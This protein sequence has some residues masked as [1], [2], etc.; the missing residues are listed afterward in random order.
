MSYMNGMWR[1]RPAGL[2]FGLD[3][4]GDRITSPTGL[5]ST[6]TGGASIPAGTGYLSL[7]GTGQWLTT[8]DAAELDVG[9][10][11]SVA[12][13]VRPSSPGTAANRV[14]IARYNAA[15]NK[16]S[17]LVSFRYADSPQRLFA[18]VGTGAA[19]P[20]VYA[21]NLTLPTSGWHHIVMT[22]D[23]SAGAGLRAKMYYDGAALA[24]S[25]LLGDASTSPLVT[26]IGVRVGN[27]ND[28]TAATAWKGDIAEVRQYNRTLTAPEI[29]QLYHAG[30]ARIAQGG[31]P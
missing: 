4:S 24:V 27:D 14:P 1:R 23:N 17:W 8:A 28:G 16:R 20:I 2:V 12:F 10:N 31:T 25:T 30:A 15:L 21:Y 3:F 6:L 26:D 22:Y 5:T 13:W 7:S 19:I 9:D 11:F 18:V 29:A